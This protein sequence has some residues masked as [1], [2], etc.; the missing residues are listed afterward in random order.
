[1]ENCIEI[2]FDSYK[3]SIILS[4]FLIS[5]F[6]LITNANNCLIIYTDPGLGQI[7]FGTTLWQIHRRGGP[8]RRVRVSKNP[9]DGAPFMK[10]VVLKT[11]IRKPKK[12]NSANRKCVIVRLS[13]GKE[14][15]AYV[16]GKICYFCLQQYCVR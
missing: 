2:F 15:T 6:Y 13:N 9:F 8:Y 4:F 11:V 1:M 3:R 10:G 16:P 7:R 5:I 12:P 14:M